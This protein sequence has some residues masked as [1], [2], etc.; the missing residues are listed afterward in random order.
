MGAMATARAATPSVGR[1]GLRAGIVVLALATA[2][3]HASLGGTLFL[4][5][6]SGY[7]TLAAAMVVPGPLGRLRPLARIGLLAFTVVTIAAWV[8]FGARFELAYID[9]AIEVILVTL[10][11]LEI[12]VEDGGP[13]GLAREIGSLAG[14][15]ASAVVAYVKGGS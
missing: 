6:A 15:A 11:A 10:L 5:N 1:I 12:Q 9:K 7:M 2:W 4:L 13:V 3:I 8:A 14:D